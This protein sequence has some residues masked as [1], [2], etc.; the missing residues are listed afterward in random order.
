MDI[1]FIT[2]QDSKKVVGGVIMAFFILIITVVTTGFFINFFLF[3]SRTVLTETKNPFLDR[4]YPASYIFKI[5]LYT[6]RFLD[7]S[8]TNHRSQAVSNE[9]LKQ[10]LPNLCEHNKIDFSISRYFGQADS[11][12]KLFTCHRTQLSTGTDEYTLTLKI[13]DIKDEAPEHAFVRFNIESEYEQIFHFFKWEYWNVWRFY[14]QYPISYSKVS[15]F[16]T[17]Q[18]VTKSN[19]NITAAFRGPETSKLKFRLTPTH[20]GNEIESQNFEGYEVFLED[21]DKGSVVNKRNMANS[22]DASGQASKG[23]SI[24]LFS[25]VGDTLN[26]VQ[27]QRR[28]SLLETLAYVFGF[29]AGFVIVAHIFKYFLSKEDYFRG[30]DR[31]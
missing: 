17:P 12:N 5:N 4:S 13:L 21:Y 9:L 6:S 29:M 10:P 19:Q 20:Y 27:V 1:P 23:I 16:V 28:K 18:M 8:D 15:G 14:Q 22:M 26:H 2:G 7:S 30:L 24:E 25:H 11:N 3:N 31:E